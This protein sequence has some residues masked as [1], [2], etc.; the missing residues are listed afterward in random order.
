MPAPDQREEGGQYQSINRVH[1]LDK[2]ITGITDSPAEQKDENPADQG[3]QIDPPF[4]GLKSL[5]LRL[6]LAYV[7]TV[8]WIQ[9]S[10]PLFCTLGA[11]G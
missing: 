2:D 1:N 9:L 6:T 8:H 10:W 7:F 5:Q 11:L 3:N 4:A